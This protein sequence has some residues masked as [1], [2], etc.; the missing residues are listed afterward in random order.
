MT[1][2]ERREMLVA[3]PAAFV[4]ALLVTSM[5]AVQEW[6]VSILPFKSSMNE[7]GLAAFT[8][9]YQWSFIL[10]AAASPA[11]LYHWWITARKFFRDKPKPTPAPSG[12]RMDDFIKPSG[13]AAH[14]PAFDF[15]PSR[16]GQGDAPASSSRDVATV[17]TADEETD[18]RLWRMAQDPRT[19]EGER[20]AAMKAIQRRGRPFPRSNKR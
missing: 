17:G 15:D 2:K 3:I 11:I 6:I 9:F 8:T 4:V 13:G 7:H 12:G 19:P 10:I 16:F 14:D 5:G 1:P 18:E 20:Q